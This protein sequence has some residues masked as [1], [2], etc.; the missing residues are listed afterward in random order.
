MSKT[1]IADLTIAGTGFLKI[2]AASLQEGAVQ[3][4]N[5]VFT[6]VGA[7]GSLMGPTGM[8]GPIGPMGPAGIA[9]PI[10]DTGM[11]GPAGE[12]G[13]IGP[14]GFA[15]PSGA[16]GP[17]GPTGATGEGDTGPEGPPG[18]PGP[19][20]GPTGPNGATGPQGPSGGDTGPTGEPGP[21]GEQGI[22][23][24]QGIEGPT[25]EQGIEGPTGPEGGPTGPTGPPG[26]PGP[27]DYLP[28]NYEEYTS[29]LYTG[30][31]PK[32]GTF[33][34]ATNEF[35]YVFLYMFISNP[36]YDLDFS[37]S[38]IEAATLTDNPDLLPTV[39]PGNWKAIELTL[40]TDQ[41][42]PVFPEVINN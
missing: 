9:G 29:P 22:Q 28:S 38:A 4:L 17:E 20:G 42:T 25:G 10:G 24:E 3:L 36:L 21:M 15:G 40:T 23:G 39:S 18:P 16:T 35:N 11:R 26:P 6:E 41:I 31:L 32:N 12:K 8:E 7:T 19:E 2:G 1:P 34:Y 5:T 33:Y 30:E 14:I 13:N 37:R 27:L